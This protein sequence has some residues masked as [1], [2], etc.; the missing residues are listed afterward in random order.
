MLSNY[1]NEK[2]RQGIF[3][4]IKKAALFR[5][6]NDI[7]L[8]LKS[9]QGTS[10]DNAD[11]DPLSVDEMEF[12]V[13]NGEMLDIR[14]CMETI[15]ANKPTLQVLFNGRERFGCEFKI[16]SDNTIDIG[17]KEHPQIDWGFQYLYPH[18]S[19]YQQS[20]SSEYAANL[21]GISHLEPFAESTLSDGSVLIPK[22]NE[23][24]LSRLIYG[25]NKALNV[26]TEVLHGKLSSIQKFYDMFSLSSKTL[27]VNETAKRV[28]IHY[29]HQQIWRKISISFHNGLRD[30]SIETSPN[31]DDVPPSWKIAA[32]GRPVPDNDEE[33][34]PHEDAVCMCCFDGAS[35]ENNRIIFCDGCNCAVHQICYG[36]TEIPEGDYFCDRCRFIQLLSHDSIDELDEYTI[37]TAVQCCL[38]PLHHGGL[39]PTTDGRWAH[40][41]CVMV[42]RNSCIEDLKEISAVDVSKVVISNSALFKMHKSNNSMVCKFCEN[43]GGYIVTCDYV[44]NCNIDNELCCSIMFHPICA[45][46]AGMYFSTEIVDPSFCESNQYPSGIKFQIFCECHSSMKRK[47]RVF[48]EDQKTIRC[49]FKINEKDLELF[50]GHNRRRRYKSRKKQQSLS[51]RQTKTLKSS[52]KELPIDSYSSMCCICLHSTERSLFSD[53]NNVN[54]LNCDISSNTFLTRDVERDLIFNDL[55][56]TYSETLSQSEHSSKTVTCRK[57][58]I[59][60][61]TKCLNHI[62][63]RY[64]F[65]LNGN[66]CFVCRSTDPAI[67]SCCLCPRRGGLLV[68]T[69]DNKW[70]HLFC[71]H[72]SPVLTRW[73]PTGELDLKI[74]AKECKK[75]KC[76]I[77]NRK[78][79]VCVQCSS[80]GCSSFFHSLCGMKS[81]LAFVRVRGSSREFFCRDHIP[82]GLAA[83]SPGCWIDGHELHRFRYCFDRARL[84]LDL[85][86]KREKLKKIIFK[87]ETESVEN[88][89]ERILHRAKGKRLPVSECDV[90]DSEFSDSDMES[91]EIADISLKQAKFVSLESVVSTGT[92]KFRLFNNNEVE[93]SSLWSNSAG[94][95]LPK[96]IASICGIEVSN[97]DIGREASERNFLNSLHK[98]IENAVDQT[99]NA[100]RIFQSKSEEQSFSYTIEQLLTKMLSVSNKEFLNFT[101][102]CEALNEMLPLQELEKVQ[103]K[104]KRKFADQDN[105]NMEL[106]PPKKSPVCD[107]ID[108]YDDVMTSEL[109]ENEKFFVSQLDRWNFVDCMERMKKKVPD[110]VLDEWKQYTHAELYKLERLLQDFLNYLAFFS[111]DDPSFCSKNLKRFSPIDALTK[112]FDEIPYKII[113]NYNQF[114]RRVICLNDIKQKLHRHEYNCLGAFF[115]DLFLMLNNARS[116]TDCN[117]QVSFQRNF[118][119]YY[120]DKVLDMAGYKSPC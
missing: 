115:H 24:E 50:P 102:N 16:E 93:V 90:E 31:E 13:S 59:A 27:D 4:P 112:D 6:V 46:F 49:N 117:S 98:L 99:R 8:L 2:E 14:N 106:P 29:L 78:S 55:L 32:S 63:Q 22:I 44:E 73:L 109:S 1:L 120:F 118:Y 54:N 92:F 47:D 5:E 20:P 17:G 19:F 74:I 68:E 111:S 69:A 40:V 114:V 100:T 26:L 41:Y 57:C 82:S 80:L 101:A 96:L 66:E 72:N 58:N 3:L 11:L 104:R 113:P 12:L 38:C 43:S 25:E 23:D 45:W 35:S 48:V 83:I 39:K 91:S 61:H 88:K 71:V 70:A 56:K 30:H 65:E 94:I 64:D 37:K 84:V 62:N 81:G 52:P 87:T 51:S 60:V 77:C 7:L 86:I 95:K 108:E 110:G 97:E 79:G 107:T 9:N 76:S 21:C 105:A 10:Y 103:P 53:S 34:E 116:V 15:L 42:A 18:S 28:G 119:L 33:L 67:I 85:I 89:Y 75:Q 36:I